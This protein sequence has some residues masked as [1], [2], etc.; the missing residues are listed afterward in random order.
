[1]NIA[2]LNGQANLFVVHMVSE[3]D[4]IHMLEYDG[5]PEV[6]EVEVCQVEVAQAEVDEVEVLQAQVDAVGEEELLEG[7]GDVPEVCEHGEVE[8]AQAEVDEVGEEELPEGVGDVP[9]VCEHGK[10]VDEV[11]IVEEVAELDEVSEVRCED[12][13]DDVGG[14]V[15]DGEDDVGGGVRDGSDEDDLVDVSV[16]GDEQRQEE[17]WEGSLF[18]EVGTTSRCTIQKKHVQARGLSDCE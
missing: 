14:G 6:G 8:V 7:V 17:H 16:H 11:V 13:E 5:Q 2:I 1:M 18:V 10:E 15:G 3:P 12:S 4:Y 9:K